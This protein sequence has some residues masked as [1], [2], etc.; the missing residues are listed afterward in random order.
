MPRRSFVIHL[1]IVKSDLDIHVSEVPP[2][3]ALLQMHPLAA[4]MAR[5]IQP[6]F[7]VEAPGAHHQ[8]IAVPFAYR[9]SNIQS[10]APASAVCLRPSVKI[11]R[12]P[13]SA[14]CIITITPG[15][16][17]NLFAERQNLPKRKPCHLAVR[18]GIGPWISETVFRDFRSRRSHGRFLGF[19]IGQDANRHI[20]GNSCA[21]RRRLRARFGKYSSPGPYKRRAF[22]QPNGVGSTCHNPRKRSRFRLP[23]RRGAGAESFT[24]PSR[25]RGVPGVG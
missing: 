22:S 4:R 6:R 13:P 18:S 12:T 14:S 19:E 3:V 17:T 8:R 2:P 23:F 1:R 9:V 11:C 16:C 15:A 10:S 21:D 7:V 24:L 20:C 25:P 5:S